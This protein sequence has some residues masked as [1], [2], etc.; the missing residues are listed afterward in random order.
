MKRIILGF[1]VMGLCA[2]ALAQSTFNDW[3]ANGRPDFALNGDVAPADALGG[4]VTFADLPS[5]LG[6]ASGVATEGFNGGATAPS[7][8]NTCTEPVND[9][10]NDVCFTPGQLLPGF[11]LTSDNGGGIVALGDGF[12][13]ANQTTTVVGANTFTDLTLV[14]FNPA[15]TAVGMDI[16]IGAPAPGDVTLTALDA[17]GGAI[18]S[19][20]I[21]TTAVD[22]TVFAGFTAA[23]PVAQVIV[24]GV[25]GGG[26]LMDNLYFGSAGAPPEP[27]QVPTL[28]GPAMWIM[29]TL[30]AGIAAFFVMRRRA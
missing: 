28:G 19:F 10:S 7:A 14:D 21:T 23:T 17:A 22:T 3:A 18:G 20:T 8:V 29:I 1:A 30:L 24:D 5:F 25:G 12:L 4:I 27:V 11:A 6:A 15:V 9:A 2:N 16:L 13:G 26:E